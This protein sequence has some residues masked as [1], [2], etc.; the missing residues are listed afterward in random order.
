MVKVPDIKVEPP[1]P[2]AR[3]II[4]VDK[5]YLA[6]STKTSPIAVEKAKGAIVQ[7]VDGNILID[8]S[9]GVSVLNIGHCHPKV[10]KAVQSQAEKV[11]H[12]AGTDY[13]YKVQSDLVKRLSHLAP[14]DRSKKVFLSNSGAETIECAMKLA[15]WHFKDRKQF[16]AFTGA[17]H[18]RT[19]GA[20][21]LT[22]SKKVQRERY[23]PLV[24]GTTHIPYPYCYR[25]PYRMEYPSCDLWCAK[26]LKEHYF[27]TVLPPQEV[28]ALFM[29]PVQ[30]EGGYIV[31]PKDW[32]STMIKIVRDH[33]ILVVDDEVQAGMG[34]TGR[35]WAIE[36]FDVIPDI[37][38]AAKSLGSGIP[39]G[40]TIFPKE[41]D[42]G[43]QGAHSNTFGGNCLA[44][45]SALA[46]LDVMEEEG[47]IGQAERKG[48]IMSKRLM[49]MYESNE[50]IGDVRGL[51]MMQAIEF[52][53]D[54]KTKEPAKHL[55]DDIVSLASKRG[56]ITLGCGR[57]SLRLIPPLVIEDEHLNAGLDIIE[58][59]IRDAARACR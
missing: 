12:F 34:R 50:Y 51:G 40:A 13:Y 31:P 42:F 18:G 32:A 38:C 46:T 11:M 14:G 20:L 44:C 3:E 58:S 59:C 53:M 17:F 41:L 1:G 25:C 6:T 4:E 19:M 15:R 37:L 8:F 9:S 24:P 5:E 49:E 47:L 39:I 52:V 33:G 26:I 45:V 55:R 10:V 48:K 28:A 21:S 30:G 43:V 7:D 27:E 35:M 2:K 56:V 57:S 22:A 54:R 23:F 29:E 16:I 36:H